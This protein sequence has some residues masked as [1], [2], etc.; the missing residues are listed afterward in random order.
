MH[1]APHFCTWLVLICFLCQRFPSEPTTHPQK[2]TLINKELALKFFHDITKR[3]HEA[4]LWFSAMPRSLLY[5]SRIS[6]SDVHI[7]VEVLHFLNQ[8]HQHIHTHESGVQK[9]RSLLTHGYQC[10]PV[11]TRV[12]K[13]IH[14]HPELLDIC[15]EI[16]WYKLAHLAWPQARTIMDVGANKGY[17]GALFLGLWGGGGL[18]VSPRV[19]YNIAMKDNLFAGAHRVEGYCEDGYD[20]ALP[21]FCANHSRDFK[22]GKCK[23]EVLSVSVHSVEGNPL[24]AKLMQNVIANNMTHQNVKSGKSWKYYN[25]ALSDSEGTVEFTK[26]GDGQNFLGWEGGRIESTHT[27]NRTVPVAMTTVDALVKSQ[28]IP[29]LDILKIDAEGFDMNVSLIWLFIELLFE[30]S[31]VL[32]I[33]SFAVFMSVY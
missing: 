2:D 30:F 22:T 31:Y 18:N 10:T 21:L 3:V 20:Q 1:F 19:M 29:S 9:F 11:Q 17:L 16:E 13:S 32:D 8:T 7:V 26:S 28:N 33:I 25:Y 6:Y 4:V 15:S 23:E 12:Q 14:S 27:P 24:L 5:N